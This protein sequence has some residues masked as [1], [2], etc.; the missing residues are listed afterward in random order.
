MSAEHSHVSA[1]GG[2]LAEASDS[3]LLEAVAFLDR[4]SERGAADRLLDPVRPRLATLR[5]PRPATLERVLVLPFEDLL[6]ATEECWPGRRRASRALLPY[7]VRTVLASLDAPLACRAFEELAGRDMRAG[8][9]IL[10]VGAALWPAAARLLRAGD[11]SVDAERR[12]QLDGVAALLELGPLLVPALWQ[13]PPKP[14]DKLPPNAA[15]VLAPVI[16][17]ARKAGDET[18]AWLLELLLARSSTSDLVLGL[19]RAS[20]LGLTRREREICADRLVHDRVAAMRR[21][22]AR[23]GGEEAPLTADM[24]GRLVDLAADIEALDSDWVDSTQDRMLLKEVRVATAELVETQVDRAVG[25]E[26]LGRL[27]ALAGPLGED[28]AAVE[29][30]EETARAVRRLGQAGVKLGLGGAGRDMLLPYLDTYRAH[31]TGQ[32]GGPQ[33]VQASLEQIRLVEILFGSNAAMEILRA[34][35]AF[36]GPNG[37]PP[38]RR[39][40]AP[41]PSARPVP[42]PRASRTAPWS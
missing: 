8:A 7:V 32:Q 37:G 12:S 41:P 15:T 29:G 22:T 18:T 30:L 11:M 34:S 6:T 1:V 23:L 31:L 16:A 36:S 4:L 21:T 2:R 39:S 14:M 17:A 38:P 26:L 40:P 19:L 28:D 13:L 5:P 27:Y 42:T 10:S 3:R 9:A 33:K 25:T 20:E 35:P 24:V